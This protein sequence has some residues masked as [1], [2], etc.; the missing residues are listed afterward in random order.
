[1][2]ALVSEQLERGDG[3]SQLSV[4]L[5]YENQKTVWARLEKPES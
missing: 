4:Q 5:L 2:C 3:I 1:M